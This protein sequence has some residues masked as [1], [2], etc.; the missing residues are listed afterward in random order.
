MSFSIRRFQSHEAA[1][2]KAIR[3]EALREDPSVFGNPY[4]TEA[5][6][7]DAI[8]EERLRNPKMACFGLYHEDILIG[9]T[10]IRCNPERLEEAYLSQSYIR[11]PFRGQGLSRILYDARID[12]AKANGVK[13]LTIGH[14]AGNVAS[15]AANQHYGFQYSHTEQRV[16]PDGVAEHM[17]HYTLQL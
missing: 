5:A 3:L 14:R 17:I 7:E 9:L 8:W 16:W 12:W 1:L 15:K 4:D 13:V 11:K 6:Y 10:S 2:Y